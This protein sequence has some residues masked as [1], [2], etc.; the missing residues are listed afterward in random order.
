MRKARLALVLVAAALLA[1]R[2]FFSAKPTPAAPEKNA[3][4]DAAVTAALNSAPPAAVA[5]IESSF[6]NVPASAVLASATQIISP[7]PAGQAFA[8]EVTSM[9]PQTVLENVRRAVRNYG[10]RFG[11]NPVGSNA[12]ITRALGGENPGQVN[13]LNPEAG[14]R[15]NDQGEMIDAWG[16]P[17]F[18][19]QLSGTVMEIHSAGPDKIMWTADDLVTK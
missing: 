9:A 10:D 15:V 6:A 19:H 16:T 3:S 13:F 17:Y 1:W 12:E 11:G 4:A 5:A 2:L 7:A 14:M 8:P 18:F